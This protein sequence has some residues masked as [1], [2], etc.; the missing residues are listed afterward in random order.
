MNQVQASAAARHIPFNPDVPL[1]EPVRE[2]LAARVA[3]QL[4]R[5]AINNSLRNLQRNARRELAGMCS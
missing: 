5:V 3:K 1:P 4:R 2:G